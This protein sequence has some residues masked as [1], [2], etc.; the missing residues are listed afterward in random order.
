MVHQNYKV[1]NIINVFLLNDDSK[2]ILHMFY[3]F[4]SSLF[5]FSTRFF[6]RL[7]LPHRMLF[8]FLLKTWKRSL[9]CFNS[10]I[11]FTQIFKHFYQNFLKSFQFDDFYLILLSTN[12]FLMIFKIVLYKSSFLLISH[13]SVQTIFMFDKI[14]III[15]GQIFY[16]TTVGKFIILT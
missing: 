3:L 13:L 14:F 10:S 6:V 2:T 16:H 8:S 9:A 11:G 5:V 1:L 4:H 12:F 15:D 7:Y